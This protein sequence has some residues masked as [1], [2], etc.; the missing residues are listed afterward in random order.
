MHAHKPSAT[1]H[2]SRPWDQQNFSMHASNAIELHPCHDALTWRMLY[3]IMQSQ[4]RALRR[5]PTPFCLPSWPEWVLD[6]GLK[7]DMDPTHLLSWILNCHTLNNAG[8]LIYVSC[9]FNMVKMQLFLLR[10]LIQE[11]IYNSSHLL[12]PSSPWIYFAVGPPFAPF[13]IIHGCHGCHGTICAVPR[14]QIHNKWC[15]W[16]H[17]NPL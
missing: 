1:V 2:Q 13:I 4:I 16:P 5:A 8:Q 12:W 10:R 6:A 11:H 9:T 14:N 7:R 17:G 3:L 15:L